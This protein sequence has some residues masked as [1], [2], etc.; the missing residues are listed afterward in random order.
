MKRL[1]AKISFIIFYLGEILKSNLRV[2]HD[3]LTPRHRMN[4]A[5][6][7]V[8]VEGMTD[9]QIVNMANFITMTP[10]T[11]GIEISED[12]HTLFIHCMFMDGTPEEVAKG[13]QDD[14]G[15]RVRR[16]FR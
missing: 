7:G 12:R 6:I 11:L 5:I 8:D 13:L 10:G 4:P 16:A 15:R 2:A 1:I 9:G 14:Y 3:V